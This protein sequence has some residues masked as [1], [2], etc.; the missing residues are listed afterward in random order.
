MLVLTVLADF[1]SAT[2]TALA[3][4]HLLV[5]HLTARQLAVQVRI[6]SVTTPLTVADSLYATPA[7]ASAEQYA[8][9]QRQLAAF[10][11]AGAIC[12][13]QLLTAPPAEVLPSLLKHDRQHDRL[14]MLVIG[15]HLPAC[16][17]LSQQLS[18]HLIRLIDHPLLL[19]PEDFA[20]ATVPRRVVFDTDRQPVRLPESANAIPELLMQL[21]ANRVHYLGEGP[22]AVEEL[23]A[24]LIPEALSIHVYTSAEAPPPGEI[25]DCVHETGLLAGLAH[26]VQTAYHASVVEGVIQ[27]AVANAADLLIFVARQHTLPGDAFYHSSTAGFMLH[28]PIPML[29]MPELVPAPESNR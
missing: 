15:R 7:P 11:D 12:Q 23:L 25:V 26:T 17:T 28:T 8:E 1:T 20:G 19:V 29:V 9:R 13:H 22:E 3:Y 18:L 2:A 4:T 24:R 21:V 14:G 5:A 6:L 27:T 10:T 16:S